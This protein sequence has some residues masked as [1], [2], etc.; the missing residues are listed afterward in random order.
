M[1]NK[2]FVL[3]IMREQGRANALDLR[4]RAKDMTGTAIIAEESKSAAKINDNVR[5]IV[6]PHWSPK[7]TY[8]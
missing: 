4:N 6:I 2:E 1:T 8:K 3:S 5:F 7:V